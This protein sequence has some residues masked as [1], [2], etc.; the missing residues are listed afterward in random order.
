VP[1]Y[2]AK[3]SWYKT[4]VK[5]QKSY[6]ITEAAKLLGISRQAVHEAIKNGLLDAKWG[7]VIVTKKALFISEKSLNSYQVSTRHQ[8]AGQKRGNA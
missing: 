8:T 2:L 6:T 5:K 4:A 7:E 1:W 3:G